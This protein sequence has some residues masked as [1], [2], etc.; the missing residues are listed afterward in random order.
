MRMMTEKHQRRQI[1]ILVSSGTLDLEACRRAERL[2]RTAGVTLDTAILELGLVDED[3]LVQVLAD[4]F[5]VTP[6]Y[7]DELTRPDPEALSRL[8]KK[9]IKSN[10]LLP[11]R[12]SG[13]RLSVAMRDFDDLGLL[14]ELA[15]VTSRRI[16]PCL[17]LE[18]RLEQAIAAFARERPTPRLAALVDRL[19]Q[20]RTL[21]RRSQPAELLPAIDDAAGA[22]RANLVPVAAEVAPA[23][24]SELLGSIDILD[25]VP[26]SS[27]PE[28]AR[29]VGPTPALAPPP[30]VSAAAPA[31]PT[32][33][34]AAV[35]ESA[36]TTAEPV[37]ASPPPAPAA[38]PRPAD[39][40]EL[41]AMLASVRERDHVA[42]LVANYLEPNF[43]RVL[44]LMIRGKEVAGW[45]G[46]GDDIDVQRLMALRISL[47]EPSLFLNL[48]EAMTSYH[49][50]LPDLP[51]HRE[52]AG[53]WGG[54]LAQRCW[55]LPISIR[56]RLVAAL[57]VDGHRSGRPEVDLEAVARKAGIAFEICI[58]RLKLQGP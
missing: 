52:L 56:T 1:E 33:P 15:F 49:G 24:G 3:R 13:T 47:S 26:A 12:L 30:D 53:V 9:L 58:L 16:E 42:E 37:P 35:S 40:E 8:P 36:A 31:P 21:S 23:S 7:A 46:R 25:Q 14:D 5:G 50:A 18:V 44:L 29:I 34:E 55:L 10:S 11:F 54:T 39:L 41:G 2:A 45:L 6:A 4:G 38:A 32:P 27:P 51:A 17:A 48:R 57:F 19:D 20:K 22:P 28:L 43:R